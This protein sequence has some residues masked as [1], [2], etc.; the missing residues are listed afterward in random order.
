LPL[1][2]VLCNAVPDYDSVG[3]ARQNQAS[4]SLAERVSD[5]ILED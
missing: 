1:N 3:K 4:Y 2:A 5:R